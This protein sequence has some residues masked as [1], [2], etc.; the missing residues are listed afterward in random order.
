MTLVNIN[1]TILEECQLC[2]QVDCRGDEPQASNGTRIL[3][4]NN[5]ASIAPQAGSRLAGSLDPAKPL[6]PA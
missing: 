3:F 5:G 4:K 6:D 2:M 1:P